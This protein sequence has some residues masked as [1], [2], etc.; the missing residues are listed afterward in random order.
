MCAAP[1]VPVYFLEGS[2]HHLKEQAD[3]LL[4][5]SPVFGG[6]RGGGNVEEGGPALGGDRLGQQGFARAGRA[7]H[8]DSLPRTHREKGER[9]TELG[10]QR[11]TG[12]FQ[13]AP[14]TVS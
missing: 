5:L 3:Q 7:D 6:Q 2:T 12:P 1:G 8:E 13:T 10:G 9:S 4:R 14:S 11:G